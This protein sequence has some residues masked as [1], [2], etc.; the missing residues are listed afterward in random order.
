[1]DARDKQVTDKARAVAA[2]LGL[3][4]VDIDQQKEITGTEWR[5]WADLPQTR[6]IIGWLAEGFVVASEAAEV[7][8]VKRR[9]RVGGVAASNDLAKDEILARHDAE[10]HRR[11]LH[12]IAKM[13]NRQD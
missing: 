9:N 5:A 2:E 10:V 7:N 3:D 11:L 1:M 8:G 12:G 4:Y 6:R 13:A